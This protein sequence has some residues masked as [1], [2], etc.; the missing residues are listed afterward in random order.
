MKPI[1]TEITETITVK[2]IIDED[3]INYKSPSMTIMFPY[4]TFKCEINEGVNCHNSSLANEPNIKIAIKDIYK[5]YASNPITE[6]IVCQGLEPFDSWQELNGLLFHFKIHESCHDMF[7]IYTGYTKDE[8]MDKV[9]Y[10]QAMYSNVI[11]KYGRF[12]PNNKK[13][14]DETLGVYLSSDNQYAERI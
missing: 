3:F 9:S 1:T 7:V 6:A 11:I 2:G 5:R 10:I 4:C 12:I 14:F 8:I 13:H